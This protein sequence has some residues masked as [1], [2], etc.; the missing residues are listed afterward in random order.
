MQTSSDE[1]SE[2][3]PPQGKTLTRADLAEAVHQQVQLPR[4]EAAEVVED[5]RGVAVVV[6][7]GPELARLIV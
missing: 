2:F 5:L 3:M 7:R 4:N 6:S 1:G